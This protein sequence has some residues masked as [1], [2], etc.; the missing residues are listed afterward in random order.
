MQLKGHT[1]TVYDLSFSPDG[2]LLASGGGDNM[3]RLWEL[4]AGQETVA[5]VKH[6]GDVLGVACSP[7]EPVVVTAATNQL[8]MVDL[9]TGEVM[10]RADHHHNVYRIEFSPDG[11]YVASGGNDNRVYLYD[12]SDGNLL[13]SGDWQAG[14]IMAI[15][16]SPN[17]SMVSV[18]SADNR[19]KI[20]NPHTGDRIAEGKTSSNISDLSFSADNT[21]LFSADVDGNLRIWDPTTAECVR[22]IERGGHLHATATSPTDTLIAIAGSADSVELWDYRT[23]DQRASYPGFE[24][25]TMALAFHPTGE[26]LAAGGTDDIVTVVGLG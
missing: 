2:R 24:G 10:G 26:A 7:T 23:S 21:R 8:R 3:L 4:A 6:K 18:G 11:R 14:D 22:C 15:A 1:G 17:G 9:A 20:Y 5:P 19:L 16:Y 13:G 25:D 12:T